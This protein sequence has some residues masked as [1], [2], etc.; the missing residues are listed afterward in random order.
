[1]VLFSFVLINININLICKVI[2]SDAPILYKRIKALLHAN[3]IR[4]IITNVFHF[5]VGFF[6]VYTLK[7]KALTK[8]NFLEIIRK[9]CHSTIF[10]NLIIFYYRAHKYSFSLSFFLEMIL[11]KNESNY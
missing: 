8:N 9:V 11:K 2:N 7:Y 4:N 5:N 3:I 10:K 1:M 6:E